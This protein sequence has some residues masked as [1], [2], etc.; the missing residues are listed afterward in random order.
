MCGI[1]HATQQADG[2]ET[3]LDN[4]CVLCRHHHRLVHEGGFGVDATQDGDSRV[5]EFLFT[6]PN[7]RIIPRVPPPPELGDEP[8]QHIVKANAEAG[9]QLD[10]RSVR[11]KGG[12]PT[13]DYGL[14]IDS[15][16][17]RRTRAPSA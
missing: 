17:A 6:T 3:K 12:S 1:G 15:L 16:I 11:G 10:D 14:A 4:L 13:M 7:G 8:I 9:L 5:V 2:G